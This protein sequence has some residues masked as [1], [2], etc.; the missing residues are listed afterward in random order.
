VPLTPGTRL[1]PYEVTSLLGAGGMGE[2]YQARD[3]R[4]SRE[5]AVK[6]LPAGLAERPEALARFKQ[7]ARVVA[8]LSH[9]NILALFDFGEEQ[10]H[11]YAVTELLAGETLQRQLEGG[12]M[13]VRK[14]LECAVQ[15]AAGLAA[16]HDRGIVHRD[17]K[18]GNLF[19]TSDGRVKILDFGLAHWSETVEGEQDLSTLDRQTTPGTV[20][21]LSATC[22]PSRPADSRSITAP[23][24]SL[25]G[26]SFTR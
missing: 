6:V 24:S 17:L 26:L 10:G 22:L 9:P 14:A 2:V 4:L 12:A 19:V 13:P 23:T 11:F 18:P 5:V 15:V 21:A 8:T 25:L 7:E 20:L 1:G 3:S 16:A